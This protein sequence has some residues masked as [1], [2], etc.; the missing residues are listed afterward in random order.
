MP[1]KHRPTNRVVRALMGFGLAACAVMLA[2]GLRMKETRKTADAA[3]DRPV[4]WRRPQQSRAARADRPD[5]NDSVIDSELLVH[6]PLA[7]IREEL[8]SLR[9][10]GRGEMEVFHA[11]LRR[12]AMADVASVAA[13]AERL[14]AGMPR[15]MALQTVAIEWANEDLKAATAWV[16]EMPDKS[17]Q[18]ELMRCI[19]AEAVRT[20]PIEALRIAVESSAG[21]EGDEIISRAA[22]EWASK[23]AAAALEWAKSIPD[24][25]LR[26]KVLAAELIAWSETA[27]ESAAALAVG[28][29]PDG[30]LLEDTVV[31]IVQ[32]WAQTSPQ[33]A[34]AWVERFPEGSLRASAIENLM[35]QWQQIDPVTA[36]QWQ[37]KNL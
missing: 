25:A 20:D 22:M 24:E 33:A 12:W 1:P 8:D 3:P 31:S 11:L 28:T 21:V 19:S 29:L 37:P 32:R 18:G 5:R 26:H 27:P 13:W 16:R 15:P 36:H 23:D 30:R 6:T 10:S 17:Q 4:D 35:S 7:R 14:P 2:C 34:A 9:L